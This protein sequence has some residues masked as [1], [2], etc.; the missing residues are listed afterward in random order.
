MAPSRATPSASSTRNGTANVAPSSNWQLLLATTALALTLAAVHPVNAQ[1]PPLPAI[2]HLPAAAATRLPSG[3]VHVPLLRRNGHLRALSRTLSQL[4]QQEIV[5]GWALREKGRVAAKYGIEEAVV[6]KRDLENEDEAEIP[7]SQLD[8]EDERLRRRRRR[9]TRFDPSSIGPSS[10]DPAKDDALSIARRQLAGPNGGQLGTVSSSSVPSSSTSTTRTALSTAGYGTATAT[11]TRSVNSATKTAPT[12]FPGPTQ[13]VPVGEVHLV[14]YDADLSY[15]APIGVGV[16]AQYMNCILDTGSADLWI[17][18]NSCTSL[19]GCTSSIPLFNSSLSRTQ[20]DMN[21]SFS[22]RY[23]SGQAQGEMMQ[24]Y[25]AFA[26]YNVSSQAFALVQSV[27]QDLLGGEISGLMGLGWQP[28]AA[29]QAVPWWQNLYQG[30]ALPFPGFAV[31]LSRFIN[32]PNASSIEPGG[33]LTF[34]YLNSS[35]YSSSINY[36]PLPSGQESY[37]L[38]RMDQIAVNGTNVTTWA[39]GQGQMAAIDTGTTLIGGP[40]DVVASIYEQVPGARAATGAYAGYYSYPCAANVSVGLTFGGVT[41][42]M[43]TADFNLGPF[44]IDSRTNQS[45]C[46]GAFFDLAFS[47]GS[48]ISWVIGAAFLK[49]VYSVYRASP[50]AVGFATLSNSSHPMPFYPSNSSD[51][52][53]DGNLT[54]I[55]GGIYGPSGAPG[56]AGAGAGANAGVRTTLVA[57]NTVTTAVVGQTGLSS[58]ARRRVSGGTDAIPLEGL[59]VVVAVVLGFGV[60]LV[61]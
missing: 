37:W 23:G 39:G 43:S 21:T 47:S 18:S 42:N 1:Q 22:V 8:G 36:V 11:G 53:H 20:M 52:A 55:P 51:P 12:T 58:F 19:T 4:D 48:R 44:G 6:G 25:V 46:L 7:E 28:L 49:N 41:Y 14:N 40:R 54:A 57:A 45:T 59:T 16:P 33:S 3:G 24:D 13:T 32:V 15:Y 17:A 38:V 35:L 34:G 26:G 61:R 29:S 30:N 2:A 27:S 60:G 9:R 10:R 50:P 5:A 31:S 56:Y